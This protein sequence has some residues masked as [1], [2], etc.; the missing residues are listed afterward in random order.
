M[1]ETTTKPSRWRLNPAAVLAAAWSAVF[2]TAQL[3]WAGGGRLGMPSDVTMRDHGAL[4]TID[5][6]AV[7][8]CLCGVLLALRITRSPYR[9]GLFVIGTVGA[10]LMLWHAALNYLFLGVRTVL[11]QP[12]TDHDR[13]YSFGYEPFWLVGGVLWLIAVFRFRSNG[14]LRSAPRVAA[15][16]L[17]GV[18]GDLGEQSRLDI[19]RRER[20][21][22][23]ILG[24]RGDALFVEVEQLG[25]DRVFAV[26]VGGEH[27]GIVGVDRDQD[28]RFHHLR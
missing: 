18:A 4:F 5:L 1:L 23:G 6:L 17:G 9:G 13:F 8:A 20:R 14:T 24:Q 16:P 27:R 10:S 19:S 26:E 3:Y 2:A 12:F 21:L 15:A 11:G 7:P 28:A 22:D 25:R